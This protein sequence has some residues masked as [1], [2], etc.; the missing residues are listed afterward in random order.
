MIVEG[1]A[2]LATAAESKVFR[3]LQAE[4]KLAVDQLAAAAKVQLAVVAASELDRLRSTA[5]A[6]G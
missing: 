2:R 1:M 4:A 5:K 3:D 6:K